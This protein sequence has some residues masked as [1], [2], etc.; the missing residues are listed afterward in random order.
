M[1][2]SYLIEKCPAYVGSERLAKFY[3]PTI[4]NS[5]PTVLIPLRYVITIMS[6]LKLCPN[7][8]IKNMKHKI[9]RNGNWYYSIESDSYT[10]NATGKHIEYD[11]I[12][13]L[14]SSINTYEIRIKV[15]ENN[16]RIL[17][18]PN[19]KAD[20]FIVTFGLTKMKDVE[21][22]MPENMAVNEIIDYYASLSD[23]IGKNVCNG[24]GEKKWMG[25]DMD[26]L[27]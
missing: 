24:N 14:N 3:I 9:S 10:E 22:Y 19:A 16:F 17:F 23:S 6:H 25:V 27:E 21:V 5:F 18:T 7:G 2:K 15:E 1:L 4:I 8:V 26:E 20:Y 12:K 13:K 11:I